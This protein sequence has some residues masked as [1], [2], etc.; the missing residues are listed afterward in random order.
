MDSH[1]RSAGKPGLFL[2]QIRR[3][4]FCSRYRL[5]LVHQFIVFL[6]YTDVLLKKANAF[7]RRSPGTS[8]EVD[9]IVNQ[10]PGQRSP[11][12]GVN[13]Q[14]FSTNDAPLRKVPSVA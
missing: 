3:S 7:K 8:D 11:L 6:R 13:L 4:E 12:S 2:P 14:T 1:Q 9:A 5:D 10:V